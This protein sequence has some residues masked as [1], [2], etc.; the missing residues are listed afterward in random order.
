MDYLLEPFD[1]NINSQYLS[2]VDVAPWSQYR[3]NVI[4]ALQARQ[5]VLGII[6]AYQIRGD[7]FLFF[8]KAPLS[9]NSGLVT[10]ANGKIY[11]PADPIRK[12]AMITEGLAYWAAMVS[13]AIRDLDPVALTI[14][15]LFPPNGPNI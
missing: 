8:D 15:G 1:G 9:L 7:L 6:M 13:A 11:D 5:P 2:S 12:Q 10:T 14:I 4:T 3:Q